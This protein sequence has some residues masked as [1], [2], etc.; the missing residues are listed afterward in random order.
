MIKKK[1]RR[2]AEI[3]TASLAD[4]AFLILIF[5]LATTTIDIDKGLGLT[6]PAKGESK[7][8]KKK[9]ITNLLINQQGEILLDEEVVEI[10]NIRKILSRKLDANELLIV[11]VKADMQAEYGVYIN[12]LDQIKQAGVTRISLAEP[13]S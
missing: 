11:S 13:E 1:A 2:T 5:F 8:I 10:K 7:S 6:L 12:V 9:N 3:P 4:I